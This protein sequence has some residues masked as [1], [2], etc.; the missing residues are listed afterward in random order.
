[1]HKNDQKWKQNVLYVKQK[2]AHHK[3]AHCY[4]SHFLHR[5]IIWLKKKKKAWFSPAGTAEWFP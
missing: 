3:H 4:V 2:R 5:F 1:M